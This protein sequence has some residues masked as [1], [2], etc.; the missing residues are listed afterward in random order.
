[1]SSAPA[2]FACGRIQD[3]VRAPSLVFAPLCASLGVV[4]EANWGLIAGPGAASTVWHGT[5]ASNTFVV[6]WRDVLLNRDTNFPVSVQAEFFD[7]GGFVYRYDLSRASAALADPS[8]ASNVLVGAWREG[9]GEGVDLASCAT[10]PASLSSVAFSALAAEDAVV[11]DRDGD[12][13]ST[14]DE[15]FVHHTDPGLVDSDG[16][17][18]SDGDEVAQSL[19]PLSA[20]VPNEELLARIEG[21]QTNMSYAAAYVAATNELVGYRL[22][23]SFSA[24][25]PA[26]A[27]N[28]VYERTVRIDRGSGWQ[29]YYLSSRPDSAGGW[30][31][32]GMVLEWEDSCGESGA[33]TASPAADSLYLPLSTNGPSFVTFRLRATSSELRSARPVYLVGYAPVVSIV[34][35]REVSAAGGDVLTVFTKGAESSIGVSIDRSRRPCNAPLHPLECDM[36]VVAGVE[37]QTGGGLRY[38][39]G[40]DGGVFVASGPGVYDLPDVSV[41]GALQTPTLRGAMP[42]GCRRRLVVLMPW[43]R[44]GDH[45]CGGGISWDGDEYVVEYEY[46]LD[47]GCLVREWHRNSGGAW[48][49]DCVPAAGCGLGDN[50]GFATVNLEYD[51]DTATAT[52]SVGGE[53]VW[54]DTAT[55][56]RGDD[57][58]GF[59]S[60]ID[61]G[62]CGG[63]SDGCESGD[64]DSLEGPSL[65]SLRFR[66]PTGM[67]RKGQVAGF[68]YLMSEGP[69]AV[70]PASFRYL[71]R[72]DVG[73]SVATNG[74]SRTVSCACERGRA[75]LIES[76]QD[77]ARVVVRNHATGALDHTWEIVNVGGSPCEVRMR[78]ISRLDNVM[79]DWTYECEQ[80]DDTGGWIWSATDNISGIREEVEKSDCVNEGGSF[81]EVRAKYGA[82]GGWLGEVETLSQVVGERECAVLR[83]VYRREDNGFGVAERT[84]DYWRDTEHPARNGSLRLLQG[85]DIPWE[86]HEWDKDGFE[87]LRV[88]Q[89]NGS[90]AP[91]D[92]PRASSNGIENASSV[93]D[94]FLTVFSYDPLEGDDAHPD[95]RGKARRESRY[96]VRDGSATLVGR[97][98]RRY[99]HVTAAGYPAVKE[100]TW[101]ASSA[102]AQFG[103]TSNAYSWRTVFEPVAP[104]GVPLVLRGETADEMDEDGVRTVSEVS[105]SGGRVALTRRKWRGGLQFPTY[106]VVEMDDV[107]GHVLRTATCLSGVGAVIEET[108]SAYDDRGRLRSSSYL[109]G[110]SET[111]AYSCCRLLWRRDREGRRTLRSAV[112]GQDGLYYA[113]EDVWLSDV[114]TNGFKVTQHFF[115]GLGR[116]TN[117]VVYVGMAPGEATDFSASDGRRMSEERTLYFGAG[118]DAAD[119][120]DARGKVEMRR[121]YRHRS[122]DEFVTDT[123]ADG[124]AQEAAMHVVRTEVRNGAC[125]TRREWDGKWTERRSW[126]DYDQSGCRID[127]EV[128]ESSDCGTVTNSV[129]RHDYLGR[130]VEASRPGGTDSMSYDG[131]SARVLSVVSTA[132]DVARTTLNVYNDFGELVGS[133]RDGVASRR[134]ETY[135][136]IS[137]EWWRV[138]RSVVSAGSA[139]N[140]ESEVRERLT[141][142]SDAVRRQVVRVSADGVVTET[143]ESYDPVGDAVA[144][145]T[146]SSVGGPA[147]R[148]LRH[149]LAVSEETQDGTT[150]FE[151]DQLGRVV[152]ETCGERVSETAYGA[153]GDV[154]SRRTRTGEGEFAEVSYAYDAF[155]NRVA[156]TNALGDVTITSYDA[157]GNVVE[158]SGASY[159]VRFAYDTEGRR[160]LLSTTRDGTIWDVT[161]WEYDPATGRRLSKRYADGSDVSCT[162]TPDLLPLRTT[163]A[164]GQWRRNTYDARRRL[165]GVEYSDGESALLDY[166]AFSNEI[167]ASNGVATAIFHRDAKGDCTNDASTVGNESKTI[168]RA[169]DEYRRLMD[170]DGTIHAYDADGLLASVSNDLAVVEYSYTPDRLDAGYTLTLSNGVVFT[171]SLVRDA[172]RR[173]LVTG[174]ESVACGAPVE[175]LA[176]AYDALNRP[177]TRGNDAFAYNDRSEVVSAQIGANS[178]AHAYDFIGNQ[179]CFVAN[180]ATNAYTHNALNQIETA[181]IPQFSILNSPFSISYDLDGNMTQCGDWTYTYDAANRLKTVSSNGVLLVTNFYDAKSR[182]VKKATSE[183]DTTFFYDGWNLVEE[184]IAYT[185]GTSSTINYFW[186]KDLSGTLQGTGGVGGLLYLTVDGCIYIPCYDNNGNI[187]RYLDANGN[188]VAQYTYDAFGNSM[189]M[190]GPLADFF[191]HRFSTKYFDPETGLYYYGYRF[192]S[193]TLMRWL[194]RDLMGEDGGTML[195]G[196]CANNPIA[197]FDA[198]GLYELTLISDKTIEGDVLMW[199]LHGNVGSTIRSNIHSQDQLLEEIRREN[200]KHGSMV[201]VLNI[202]GHGLIDGSGILFADNSGFD[203]GKSYKILKPVLARNATIKIWSCDAAST[204]RKCSDLRSAAEALEATI[205]ANTGEVM[206]GPNGNALSR[207]SQRVVAWVTGEKLGEWKIFTPR[208]KMN[209]KGFTSGPRAFRILKEERKLND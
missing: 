114:A 119:F 198:F 159:P 47:S 52:V 100:E 102:A 136:E 202:S 70:S 193:P 30:S 29:Q 23:D 61:G 4:P 146:V 165:V 182:R 17:G 121:T 85:D 164:S 95:D 167:A 129:V 12:G 28:L 56:V 27:T 209:S 20:S 57:G 24:T 177:T 132:G 7:D 19:D 74:T 161:T 59:R 91:T 197:G 96:V 35:G 147:V 80:D 55:H 9:F 108:L 208:P 18:V 181:T 54:S 179:T 106:E 43:V 42:G 101:R 33:A 21:F 49:C 32:G 76:V 11:A 88:E 204:Y 191:R 166:D 173:S 2:V 92:F 175:S 113:M 138:T 116:E 36:G 192:Y 8:V 140:S 72:G 124:G 105:A 199:F 41:S 207:L 64:C 162:Y 151:H 125:A 118:S 196:M 45:S 77:G 117:K 200:S 176:Y 16:D 107:H 203:V 73:A 26:G 83:E 170:M 152:R 163:Y 38:E 67:P 6:T 10:N 156:E 184:R 87:T 79:Q 99:S 194:N 39:G 168:V 63:C 34:G 186:G 130:Q 75:L 98:W 174:V 37:S 120:V 103:D 50:N 143:T 144:E 157:A 60:E 40:L 150:E 141:G 5:T 171:R 189:S 188:T 90:P 22:W 86:Y 46:P 89:R 183:A 169:F 51:D 14:Y 31:L 201:T 13:L 185:N 104:G 115:D 153:A 142:L 158:V 190:S 81:S 206:A 122:R 93:Q 66:I 145:T 111:N 137:N 205:Y 53:A 44:Y 135:E 180:A 148:T 128:T 139:T 62:E 131:S 110:T 68:A 71:L 133:V 15:I 126:S 69:I 127:Y 94:A 65:G 149:G 112:T 3:A 78:Q 58:D 154:A 123:Y 109:D 178:F 84:A 195:Y 155:G 25:W 160:T 172:Y 1:M 82:D 134:D 187:T 48:S 97:T